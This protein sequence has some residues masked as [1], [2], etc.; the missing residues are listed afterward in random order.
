MTQ[1]MPKNLPASIRQRLLNYA[2]LHGND[3]Q[4]VLTRY[5]IERLLVRICR[6]PARDHYILKGAMLFA[7]WPEHAFRPTGDLDLLGEGDPSPKGIA[8]LFVDICQIDGGPDGIV[9]DPSTLLVEAVRGEENNRG[10]RVTVIGSVGA[11]RARVQVDIGF[12]DHVHPAAKRGIFP[13][14]LA[15]LPAAEMLMYPPETVV[16]EK[17][18][19]MIRFGEAN[20]RIKD[21]YDIWVTA[22]TF[23]F[24]LATL[25][26]AVLGTMQ[27]RQTA[28]PRGLPVALLPAFAER[29]AT[30]AL[31][32]GFLR[33]NPP[34][35]TPPPF[36]DLLGE[37]RQFFGPVLGALA[38]LGAQQGHWDPH[39]RGWEQ[40]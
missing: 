35:L 10:A 23:E 26:E 37:L 7:T 33:R 12:G 3:Y 29:A 22:R 2:H 20:G 16:A 8:T 27:R 11:A 28:D 18:E 38:N 36:G 1:K 19:T 21:F 30:Q 15:G 14:L 34:A 9:F 32:T 31:W 24:D 25:T 6:S 5:A 40:L 17:L 39:R 13:G 4:R